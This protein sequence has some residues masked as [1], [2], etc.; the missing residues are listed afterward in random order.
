MRIAAIGVLAVAAMIQTAEAQ[1]DRY[2]VVGKGVTGGGL[3]FDHLMMKLDRYTGE[4]S[5]CEY[6]AS[7]PAKRCVPLRGYP[8]EPTSNQPIFEIVLEPN[9]ARASFSVMR[10]DKRNG[11]FLMCTSTDCFVP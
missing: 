8:T 7:P 4:L 1:N 2:Q 6:K 10:F 5:A 9:P 11:D 3:R